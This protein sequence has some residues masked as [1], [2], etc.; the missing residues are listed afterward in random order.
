[1]KTKLSWPNFTEICIIFRTTS[2]I[3][4]YKSRTDYPFVEQPSGDFCCP[5]TKGLLLEPYLTSCC[6]QHLSQEAVAR[7]KKERGKCPLCKMIQWST[8]LDKHY[9][10]EVNSLLVFCHYKD[11][12]CT[13]QGELSAFEYHV[14]S[15]PMKDT[16]LMKELPPQIR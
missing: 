16:P 10:R 2:L 5:Y 14:S 4:Q 3:S 7:I 15:C 12:G 11:R 13:W 6:G 9:Q 8:M 1:M